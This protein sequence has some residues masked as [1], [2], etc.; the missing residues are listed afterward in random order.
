MMESNKK[1]RKK[2]WVCW[3]RRKECCQS[4]VSWCLIDDRLSFKNHDTGLQNQVSMA[5]GILNSVWKMIP[6]E[7][8]LKVYYA[9]I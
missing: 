3:K 5:T 4:K 6:A 2:G 1:T 7:V 9:L 8:K